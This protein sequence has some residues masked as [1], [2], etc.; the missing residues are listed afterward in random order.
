VALLSLAILLLVFR[1]VLVPIAA[2]A[3]FLLSIGA[4]L[5][6]VVTAFSNPDVTWLVGVDRAGPVLSFL[7]IMATGILYGLAM[8]Y[9]VFLGTSI[10]EVHVH[11]GSARTA[12]VEGFH[13]ASRVVVA[14]ALIMIS[15]FAGFVLSDDTMIRQFGFAL[16]AGILIDAFLIR[17]TLIPVVLHL[18]GD[19]A[20]WLPRWLGRI[21]PDLDLEG[22]RLELPAAPSEPPAAA[23]SPTVQPDTLVR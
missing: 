23:L 1:S 15:V 17:M 19:T 18:A 7:P 22:A 11:G 13:H 14:A 4:T 16:S 21:L 2:T 9:Q 5:G 12:V 10:R 6:L 20:W 3:G 8:D